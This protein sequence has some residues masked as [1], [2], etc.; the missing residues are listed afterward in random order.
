MR[1]FSFWVDDEEDI[2]LVVV[3]EQGPDGVEQEEEDHNEGL[4]DYLAGSPGLNEQHH[5]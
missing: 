4:L 1:G 2:V 5:S 3:Q